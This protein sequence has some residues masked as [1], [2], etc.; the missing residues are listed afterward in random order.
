MK[1]SKIFTFD[2]SHM[3]DGHDGK[4]QNLHGH[5]YQLEVTVASILINEGAKAGM[6]MD[7]ADLKTW[8]KQTILEPFDHAFLY[9]G[10][11]ERESQI[12]VLLEGW[13]MKTLRLNQRTT[14][15]HL[16]IE[17]YHRLQAVGVAVC[18]IKLWETPTSY[19]EY[20]GE[21]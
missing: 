14:A 7:F 16:A 18:R 10:N 5:T 13:Q 11:N 8:V 21:A 2:A 3:L 12:A 19:A 15:E 9:H 4:C 20:E 6:V 17:M 1:I